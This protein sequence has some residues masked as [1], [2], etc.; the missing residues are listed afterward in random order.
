MNMEKICADVRT[1]N[2][3]FKIKN[4]RGLNWENI[5]MIFP[6]NL[7][8]GNLYITHHTGDYHVFMWRKIPAHNA[9]MVVDYLVTSYGCTGTIYEYVPPE[10]PDYDG[11]SCR[12]LRRF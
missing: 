4:I 5:P 11:H 2:I 8:G 10:R 9:E 1:I 6:S 3:Q 7:Y 12:F